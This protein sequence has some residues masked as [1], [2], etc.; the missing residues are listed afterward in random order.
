MEDKIIVEISYTDKDI[1]NA[2]F[3][4]INRINSLWVLSVCAFFV[5]GLVLFITIK[6]GFS[7][8]YNGLL[9]VFLIISLL[10]FAIYYIYPINRY[11][12]VYKIWKVSTFI[13]TSENIEIIRDYAQ[14]ICKWTM[15]I[16][17]CELKRYFILVDINKS[18]TILP[19]SAFGDE[20][21]I[22][23]FKNILASK[24]KLLK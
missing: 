18:L 2:V 3:E 5:L 24:M 4:V 7:A 9:I 17:A 12:K 1:R 23:K 22:E 14:S 20:S 19:K 11:I 8:Y 6:N 16:K 15:F 21:D 10:F 13:F